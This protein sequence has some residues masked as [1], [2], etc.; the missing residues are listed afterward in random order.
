MISHDDSRDSVVAA[1]RGRA[2]GWAWRR[3]RSPRGMA[4]GSAAATA[5]CRC[6][7]LL[8]S[9]ND[10]CG[11][12]H[13]RIRVGGA[14]VS[15]WCWPLWASCWRLRKCATSCSLLAHDLRARRL[16]GPEEKKAREIVA[17]YLKHVRAQLGCTSESN[18]RLACHYA[19]HPSLP[20]GR[21][22][23]SSAIALML[24]HE[25]GQIALTR[26]SSWPT[27]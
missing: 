24:L 11:R 6:V 15:P 16:L 14:A 13:R 4:S 9:P 10:W 3:R 21:G 23:P 22:R 17:R 2:D 25:M 19:P 5:G 1:R 8:R 27:I 18:H 7:G 20:G 26:P 12:S